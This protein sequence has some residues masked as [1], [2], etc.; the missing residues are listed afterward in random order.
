[1]TGATTIMNGS[2]RSRPK[3]FYFVTRLKKGADYTVVKRNPVPKDGNIT[4]DQV[5]KINKNGLLLRRIGLKDKETG[6]HYKFL[7]NNFQLTAEVVAEIFRDRWEIEKFFRWIKQNLKIKTF[8]GRNENAVLSQVYVAM[9]AYLL[10][11]IMKQMSKIE[12]SMQDILQIMQVQLMDKVSMDELFGPPK[13]DKKY[14][15]YKQ[16]PLTG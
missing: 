13:K 4:S 6:K 2:N 9:I 14:C 12:K 7:T 15:K 8:V 3:V 1:M 10:L 11:F 16:L 5:I